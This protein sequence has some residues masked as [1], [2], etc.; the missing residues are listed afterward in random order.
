MSI[1]VVWVYSEV[2]LVLLACTYAA[3]GVALHFVR[4]FRHRLVS[5]TA[6]TL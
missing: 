4:F 1:A 3:T 5:R 6:G 2:A